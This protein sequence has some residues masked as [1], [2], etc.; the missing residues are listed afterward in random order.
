MKLVAEFKECPDCKVD[1]RLMNPIIQEEIAKGNMSKNVLSCAS[2][3]ITFVIDPSHPP[4]S[5][6]RV[7]GARVLRDI[8]TKCGRTYTVRIESG[9]VTL[10]A[11]AG[12]PVT[13]A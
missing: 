13:F 5:G 3:D 2:A 12:L 7:P 1:A 6:G 9:Y 10:P 11:R 4:I 8:C